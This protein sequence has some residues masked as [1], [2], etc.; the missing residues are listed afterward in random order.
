M[1][2]EDGTLDKVGP[3][4]VWIAIGLLMIVT[5]GVMLDKNVGIQ[6]QPPQV[7]GVSHTMKG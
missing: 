2:N 5:V 6:D 4:A 7:A 3:W 1:T